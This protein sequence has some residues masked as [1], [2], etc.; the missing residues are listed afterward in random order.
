MKIRIKGNSI[1]IRLNRPE[2]EAFSE[3]EY[4]E[5][6]TEFGTG[7]FIYALQ[8]GGE[9]TLTATFDGAKM[10]MFVP[11]VLIKEW[12]KETQ[13]GFDAHMDLGN[14]KSLYLLLEKDF[15]CLD[16]TTEDQSDNFDNPLLSR[17]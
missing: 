16:E 11:E 4:I 12:S 1:R 7:T 2:V 3:S 9:Q 15:K 10:T 8:Q 14:G 5:E 13:V 17:S 6:K